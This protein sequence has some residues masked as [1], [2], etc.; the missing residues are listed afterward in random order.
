MCLHGSK[1]LQELTI[2]VHTYMVHIQNRLSYIP[3]LYSYYHTKYKITCSA[4][5]HKKLLDV[6]QTLE[7]HTTGMF[8][9][10]L[11]MLKVWD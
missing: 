1:I 5:N 10:T 6:Q 7:P 8:I 9:K 4:Y 2:A 3:I 11:F